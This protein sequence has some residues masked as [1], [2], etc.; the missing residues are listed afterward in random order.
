MNRKRLIITCTLFG[1]LLV[2]S[3]SELGVSHATSKRGTPLPETMITAVESVGETT[4]PRTATVQKQVI[5][6]LGK[7]ISYQNAGKGNGQAVINRNPN[8]LA[9]TWGGKAIQSGTDNS[10]THFIGH[11]PGAFNSLISLKNGVSIV[12]TDSKG[13]AK[14][15]VV[16]A[17]YKVDDYAKGITNG[18]N[19]W[20]RITGT[21]G[22]ERVTFQT[23]LTSKINLIVEAKAK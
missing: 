11:N 18:V 14:T 7:T 12:I 13:A 6:F 9:S 21:S 4:L 2:N 5:K 20:S 10:N 23:C 15:Y 22:G 8:S 1:S 16:N 3:L 19:Y 17:I